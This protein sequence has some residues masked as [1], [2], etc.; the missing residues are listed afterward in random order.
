M[1]IIYFSTTVWAQ[2]ANT[3]SLLQPLQ[4]YIQIKVHSREK[5][6]VYQNVSAKMNNACDY[7]LHTQ[8]ST[9]DGNIMQLM[10]FDYSQV[11]SYLAIA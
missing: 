3:L 6:V 8:T 7:F 9:Q 11:S 10:A 5:L 4:P 2:A 1:I